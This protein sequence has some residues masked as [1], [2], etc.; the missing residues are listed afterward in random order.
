MGDD[1]DVLLLF[2]DVLFGVSLLELLSIGLFL[3]FCPI[4]G[5]PLL[6]CFGDEDVL[7]ALGFEKTGNS[8]H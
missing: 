2:D 3:P 7:K 6:L 5:E 1:C 4:W 8:K